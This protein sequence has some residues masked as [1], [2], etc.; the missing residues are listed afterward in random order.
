VRLLRAIAREDEALGVSR[1]RLSALSVLEFGGP[2]SLGELARRETVQ[3]PTMSRLVAALEAEGL[4]ERA[5]ET[6]D[7]RQIRLRTTPQGRALMQRGRSRRA[8]ALAERL[9]RLS[10]EE[11]EDLEHSLG[12]LERLL[13][14]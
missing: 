12:L 5:V 4:V 13:A 11:L 8:A 10:D 9:A 3:P 6:A 14:D 1:A 7:R 2:M